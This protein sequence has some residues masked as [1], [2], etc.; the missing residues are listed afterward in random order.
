MVDPQSGELRQAA[1]WVRQLASHSRFS[2]EGEKTRLSTSVTQLGMDALRFKPSA[3]TNAVAGFYAGGLY[4]KSKTKAASFSKGKI[5]GFALG[6][7]GTFYT[8]ADADD[9][10][11]TDT[12][13]QYGRY[14]NRITGED[15]EL[16]FRSHGFT[17]SV[18]TGYSFKLAKTGT[19]KETDFII[20][21]QAQLIV[22]DLKNNSVS[23]THGYKFKQLGKN[24][25]TIRL[26]A[27]FMVKQDT[28][29]TAF[30]EGN[31]LHNTKKAGVQMGTEGVYMSGGKNTGEIRVGA[32]GSLSRNLKGWVS[33]SFRAGQSGYHTES[34][35]V[36]LK[37]LF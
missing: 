11:Y 9:G 7:Y 19:Q 5:D 22:T 30:V 23:D 13:L 2:T 24:N 37:L 33:G 6:V 21:P 36:G 27:R 12:W 35:Q 16:K 17:F 10:F 31:W 34:A 4:G 14:D 15:P 26:G 1:G 18:E 8:G 29:L 32:E 28:K 20:Q 3:E 25:A